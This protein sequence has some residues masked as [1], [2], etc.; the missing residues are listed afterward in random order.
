MK[1]LGLRS[2]YVDTQ[3]LVYA[4]AYA[5]KG[6]ESPDHLV[7]KKG[8]QFEDCLDSC[9]EKSIRVFTSWFTFLELQHGHVLRGKRKY[10][11]I[12][13]GLPPPIVFGRASDR[14]ELDN[15]GVIPAEAMMELRMEIDAWLKDWPFAEIVEIAFPD[16]PIWS[17]LSRT[18]MRYEE[19]APSDCLHLSAALALECDYFMTEDRPLRRSLDNLRQNQAFVEEIQEIGVPAVPVL[20]RPKTFLT[21]L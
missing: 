8:K 20:T 15:L 3:L 19:V 7:F 14:E 13:L 16:P 18:I 9:R 17:E 1:V 12:D 2:V 4:H 11:I 6:P 10:W 21:L 5:T